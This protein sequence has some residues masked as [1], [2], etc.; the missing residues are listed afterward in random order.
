[1]EIG[2]GVPVFEIAS[3]KNGKFN[4]KDVIENVF[5]ET[6]PTPGCATVLLVYQEWNHDAAPGWQSVVFV[7]WQSS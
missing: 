7:E 1:M 2:K 3:Y 5:V 6:W 4:D